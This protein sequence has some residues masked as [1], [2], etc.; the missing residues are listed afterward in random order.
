M[1]L[2][3]VMSIT[4]RIF[5][6]HERGQALGVWAT[7]NGAAHGL[8]PII[9]GFLIEYF[10]WRAIFWTNGLLSIL[11]SFLVFMLVPNDSQRTKKPFDILGA[12]TE[13]QK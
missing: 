3:A 1:T 13:Y 2:P 9:S 12:F 4:T 6:I 7:V 8:G 10:D 5:P 11:G